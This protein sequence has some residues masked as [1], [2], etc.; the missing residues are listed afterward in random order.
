M[1][2]FNRD[3]ILFRLGILASVLSLGSCSFFSTAPEPPEFKLSGEALGQQ[4]KAWRGTDAGSLY[5]ADIQTSRDEAGNKTYL[6]SGG[7]LYVI[8]SVPPIQVLAPS[9]TVTPEFAATLGKATVKKDGRLYLGQEATK[10]RIE[11]TTLKP[12]GAHYIRRID[13]EKASAAQAEATIPPPSQAEPE[14]TPEPKPKVFS[15]PKV[16]TKAKTSSPAKPQPAAA[17]PKEAPAVDRTRLLNLMR[18]PTAP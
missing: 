4:Y 11:G 8:D 17:Q 5:A 1:P 13:A 14:A 16:K 10:F 18:E 15:K 6:A 2:L 3:M 7:A 12:D 9:I